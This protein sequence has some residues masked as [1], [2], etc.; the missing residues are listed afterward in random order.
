MATREAID[1][2]IS[3][4]R[5]SPC[6]E[7]EDTQGFEEHRDELLAARLQY[8]AERTDQEHIKQIA[9]LISPARAWFSTVNMA[10]ILGTP[11]RGNASVGGC[12]SSQALDMLL[13][14]FAEMPL[15]IKERLDRQ[16]K[17]MAE[18]NAVRCCMLPLP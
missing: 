12:M 17:E 1:K 6:W 7:L 10:P 3:D 2:L 13:V 5:V 9:E 15:P 14:A 16:A 11:I 8:E 4:W 18:T